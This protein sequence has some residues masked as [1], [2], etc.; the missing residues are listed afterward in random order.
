MLGSKSATKKAIKAGRLKLNGKTATTA[1]YVHPG[2]KIELFGSGIRKAK[3]INIPLEI[4]YEDDHLVM[5]NKPGGIAVNGNRY[6]TVENAM[7]GKVTISNL[8]DALPRPIAVHRIDVPTNGLLVMAKSKSALI[9]MTK[10]F[11]ERRVE[12][13]YL[14]IVHGCPPA[15]LRIDKPIDKKEAV[16]LLKKVRTVPSRKYHQLSLVELTPITGRTHQLRIHMQQSDHLIVGDRQY[17]DGQVTLLGKGVM[18]CSASISFAHP[19]DQTPVKASIEPPAKFKR[20]LDREEA[21]YHS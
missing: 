20:I 7:V 18:L 3:A 11:Q 2:D 9:K 16:T 8:T 5:V 4:V 13:T 21:R 14:A 10:A 19:I 12:K 15:Q 1:S 17:A 6:K